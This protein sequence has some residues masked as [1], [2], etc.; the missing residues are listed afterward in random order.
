MDLRLHDLF[1]LLRPQL[2]MGRLDPC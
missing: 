1:R 2:D